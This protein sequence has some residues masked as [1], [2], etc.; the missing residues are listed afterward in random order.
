MWRASLDPRV[1]PGG[2]EGREWGS[3]PAVEMRCCPRV[4]RPSGMSPGL[5]WDSEIVVEAARGYRRALPIPIA[6]P[7]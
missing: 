6:T 5:R 2:D 7:A 1:K 4:G 3:L